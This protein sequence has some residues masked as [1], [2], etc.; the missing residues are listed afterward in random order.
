[1]GGGRMM[2]IVCRYH[3]MQEIVTSFRWQ[4]KGLLGDW[5]VVGKIPIIHAHA[6]DCYICTTVLVLLHTP[7]WAYNDAR[8]ML[9]LATLWF[10]TAVSKSLHPELLSQW[11]P[12]WYVNCKKMHISR[13]QNQQQMVIST[14]SRLKERDG[15]G[16]RD[17]HKIH[18]VHTV[19]VITR[20]N[21][22]ILHIL[23]FGILVPYHRGPNQPTLFVKIRTYQ[24]HNQNDQM[25]QFE[26]SINQ[27]HTHGQYM[28]T[29]EI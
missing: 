15:G 27:V 28:D 23:V 3:F 4:R 9:A 19:Q 16:E 10:L 11:T 21:K 1:M 18:V 22:H 6:R 7:K 5:G 26:K 17:L 20:Q 2:E 14:Q 29:N 24:I 8:F 12:I 13:F 25:G